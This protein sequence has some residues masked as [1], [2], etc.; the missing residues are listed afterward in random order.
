VA[1]SYL[2]SYADYYNEV[3][4]HRSLNKDAPVHRP[5]LSTGNLKAHPILSGLHHQY[6]GI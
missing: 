2:R 5:V 3:R 4:T 1:L 6:V